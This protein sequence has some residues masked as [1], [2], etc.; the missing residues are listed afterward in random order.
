MNAQLG[1]TRLEGNYDLIHGLTL[2]TISVKNKF[3]YIPNP[4]CYPEVEVSNVF[5]IF[6]ASAFFD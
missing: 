2:K 6:S 4:G 1:T 3:S 5:G